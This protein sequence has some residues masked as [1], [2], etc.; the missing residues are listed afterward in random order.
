MFLTALLFVSTS[1]TASHSLT[2][3]EAFAKSQAQDHGAAYAYEDKWDAVNNEN[4]LDEKDGC[5]DKLGGPTDQVLVLDQ[6]GL[7]TSVVAAANTPQSQCFQ[8]A[9]LHF[10]FPKPPA[11]PWYMHLKMGGQ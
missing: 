3:V 6:N 10:R 2:Y 1:V 7:V 11:S 4:H 5:Y 8:K 9:Y